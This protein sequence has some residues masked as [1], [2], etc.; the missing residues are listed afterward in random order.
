M[1]KIL[2]IYPNKDLIDQYSKNDSIYILESEFLTDYERWSQYFKS[3]NVLKY[4]LFKKNS[5]SSIIE[6]IIY[7]SPVWGR[8]SD[9][10]DQFEL[11]FRYA[12]EQISYI[13][14]LM[15]KKNISIAI[16][17]TSSSHHIDS[18]VMQIACVVSDV[19]QVFPYTVYSGDYDGKYGRLL[20]LIQKN[21]IFDRKPID[22]VVSDFKHSKSIQKLATYNR[23]VNK[24]SNVFF[25]Y[26]STSFIFSV[27]K[28]LYHEYRK[29]LYRLIKRSISKEKIQYSMYDEYS[30]MTHIRQLNSQK[31]AL[32]Y[33]VANL[34]D[35]SKI[36]KQKVQLLIAAHYQPE[37]TSFP[38]GGNLHNHV[39]IVYELRSK[40]YTD[41]ILYKEHPA[42]W[43]YTADVVGPT[44]VAQYRSK[45][46]FQQLLNLGCKFLDTSFEL[47]FDHSENYFYIPITIT[48]SIA[49]ERSL[50]GLHTIITG[51][52]W[53][54][55]LPGTI[56]ISEIND[57]S[58]IS[59]DMTKKDSE[60]AT[61]AFKFLENT[62][63]NKTIFNKL[64]IATGQKPESEEL[65]NI[66][67]NE[68]NNLIQYL[69]NT[70]VKSF[71]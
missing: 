6:K 52:P 29:K 31:N 19:I 23:N 40:G 28:I 13:S 38:E 44:R 61:D 62:L 68:Y 60:I 26:Y 59:M 35:I 8:W 45:R 42:T 9:K 66:F 64:G 47:S 71:F 54:K 48:G 30:T 3:E 1:N 10:G 39:D 58:K 69:I 34:H 63:N 56:H 4:D 27:F 50:N 55:G 21:N 20:P 2:L 14:L 43:M 16:F 33:Y 24:N 7:F 25:N 70:D 32:K 37:A 41:A 57:L 15:K 22:C 17:P 11:Y 53:Y 51:H 12:L 46:Y 67:I 18:V 5:V 49:I 36:N 65:K